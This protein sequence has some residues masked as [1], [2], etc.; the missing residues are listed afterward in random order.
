M[1]RPGEP[2]VMVTTDTPSYCTHLLATADSAADASEEARA[3][4]EQG[5]QLCAHGDVRGGI[6]RLRQALLLIAPPP[7]HK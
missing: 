3:L 6:R 4:T 2:P 5:R 1:S 7:R